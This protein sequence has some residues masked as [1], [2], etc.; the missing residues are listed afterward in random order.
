MP[1]ITSPGL[2]VVLVQPFASIRLMA[3]PP[4][5][6]FSV[7]PSLVRTSRVT[8]GCGFPHMNSKDKRFKQGAAHIG[9]V[10][11]IRECPS[12]VFMSTTEPRARAVSARQAVFPRGAGAVAS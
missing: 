12:L 6:H 10:R 1:V 9:K 4:I 3:G 7:P 8:I 11:R 2:T 5:D